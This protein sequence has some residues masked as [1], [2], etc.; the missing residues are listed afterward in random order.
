MGMSFFGEPLDAQTAEDWGLIWKCVDDD[1]LMDTAQEYAQRLS[2]SST[3]AFIQARK[4][5]DQAPGNSMAQQLSLEAETQLKLCDEPA[6]IGG[7]MK[8]LKKG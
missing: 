2:M 4:A 8:F 6:F 3:A 7:V 1:K 5:F